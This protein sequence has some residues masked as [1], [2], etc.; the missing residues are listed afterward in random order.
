M[1]LYGY[2]SNS[3]VAKEK[4]EMQISEPSM[5]IR[6]YKQYSGTLNPKVLTKKLHQGINK[7][8]NRIIYNQNVTSLKK[9]A[10]NL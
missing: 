8:G 9:G 10:W 1:D 2:A 7:S 6:V 3:R 5:F 4:F